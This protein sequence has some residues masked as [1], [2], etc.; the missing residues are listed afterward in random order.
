MTTGLP[1]ATVTGSGV[2]LTDGLG[3]ATSLGAGHL[4]T[5]VA[6]SITT[7]VGAGRRAAMAIIITEH[8]GDPR[9]SSSSMS[10]L[11]TASASAG[12]HWATASAIRVD[13]IINAL[14]L[15]ARMTW[16]GFNA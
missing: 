15:C 4:I 2:R 3:S 13:D 11:L 5:M 1:I 7:T 16:R 12:I 9:L 10:R 6:G 8:G 14:K